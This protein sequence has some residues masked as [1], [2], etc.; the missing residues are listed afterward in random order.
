MKM[1]ILDLYAPY[2]MSSAK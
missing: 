2:L 1:N